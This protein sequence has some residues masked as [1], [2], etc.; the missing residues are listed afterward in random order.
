MLS[1]AINY[2]RYR[3][4]RSFLLPYSFKWIGLGFFV[5]ALIVGALTKYRVD[6]LLGF[7]P[8][9]IH[10]FARSV[11][12]SSIFCI[13]VSSEK[14]EDEILRSI[15]LKAFIISA[16]WPVFYLAWMPLA[17]L[18][19]GEKSDMDPYVITV[20]SMLFYL[21]AFYIQRLRLKLKKGDEK[22][23]QS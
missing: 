15:R 20:T 21:V 3:L 13:V 7:N 12:I 1:H 11:A 6:Y 19:G 14:V 17:D 8:A 2:A 22:H 9:I 5:L 10:L 4:S 18:A 16:I 23:D